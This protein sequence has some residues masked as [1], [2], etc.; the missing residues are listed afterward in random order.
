MRGSFGAGVGFDFRGNDN[1][2]ARSINRDGLGWRGEAVARG[3][4]DKYRRL[5]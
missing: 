5:I 1:V 4:W 2:G 3:I